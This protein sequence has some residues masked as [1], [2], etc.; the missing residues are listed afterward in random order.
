MPD[1]KFA[2]TW[3]SA[4]EEKSITEFDIIFTEP[5][6]K[7][8]GWPAKNKMGTKLIDKYLLP[9][10][11]TLWILYR[12][13]KITKELKANIERHKMHIP[14]SVKNEFKIEKDESASFRG[15]IGSVEQDGS[16]TSIEIA[17][18]L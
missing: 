9:N 10:K 5:G 8:T 13:E 11:R 15:V 3:I 6:A 16:R 17:F 7:V 1:P 18:K 4:P 14:E 12:Y 2:I